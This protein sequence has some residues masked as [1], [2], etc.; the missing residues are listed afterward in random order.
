MK[1]RWILQSDITE[2]TKSLNYTMKLPIPKNWPL[3]TRNLDEFN[4]L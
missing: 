4:D 3:S 2:A 1:N